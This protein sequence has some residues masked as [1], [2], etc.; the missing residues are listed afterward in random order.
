MRKNEYNSLD[1]FLSQYIGVWGPSDGHWFGLDFSYN[2]EEYRLHTGTMYGSEDVVDENGI[3]RQFGL[4][5][6]TNKPDPKYPDIM[7]YE[8]LDEKCS[9]DELLNSTVIDGKPF[10]EVIMDDETELLGQD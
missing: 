4:Y 9:M 7:L 3:V 6:K 1:E 5:R 8:M 10:R 2:D